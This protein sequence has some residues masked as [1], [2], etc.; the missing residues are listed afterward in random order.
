MGIDNK[1]LTWTENESSAFI[2]GGNIF[3]PDRAR[4][5]QRI[6]SLLPNT[7][8]AVNVLDICCGEGLLSFEIA[9][10]SPFYEMRCYDGSPVMLE[11][12]KKRLR[13]LP[14]KSHFELFDLLIYEQSKL[15]EKC[16]AVVSSL[17]LHHLNDERKQDF[18]KFANNLLSPKGLFVVVDVV[19]PMCKEAASIAAEDWDIAAYRQSIDF[20]G[21]SSGYKVFQEDK[22]N[23]YHYLE[24]KEYM[25]YDMP[26]SLFDQ[27]KW[28]DKAGFSK[29]D[30]VW[31]YAG[32]AIF[33]RIK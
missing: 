30:V 4:Q 28:L 22:W 2:E 11:N 14:N 3:V 6:C 23:I 13:Q 29:V 16:C 9:K 33:Y 7:S 12:T 27:L 10:K 19:L 5:Y 17:A 21:S 18:F 31:M 8:T 25:A 15:P 26:S 32:H 20:T 1:D 24:D